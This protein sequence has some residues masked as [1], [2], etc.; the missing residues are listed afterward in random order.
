MAACLDKLSHEQLLAIAAA[1]C[2]A[3][4]GVQKIADAFVR[5]HLGDAAASVML[6]IDLVPHLLAPLGPC[7]GA[8]AAVCKLWAKAWKDT[9]EFR[10]YLTKVAFKFNFPHDVLGAS[11][12]PNTAVPYQHGNH[13]I[14]MAVVS[15]DD[16]RAPFLVVRY[17][18]TVSIVK[19]DMTCDDHFL[20]PSASG[21]I[22]ANHDFIWVVNILEEISFIECRTLGG[23]IVGKWD[24]VDEDSIR[25]I[26]FPVVAPDQLL[27][28]VIFDDGDDTY[29]DKIAALNAMTLELLFTF[30]LHSS[31]APE[32]SDASEP[33]Q[34]V[35]HELVVVGDELFVCDTLNSQLQVFS[36]TG[37]HKRA[38]EGAWQRPKY[39]C[40]EKDRLYLVEEVNTSSNCVYMDCGKRIFVLS[41]KGETLQVLPVAPSPTIAAEIKWYFLIMP[42]CFDGKLLVPMRAVKKNNSNKKSNQIIADSDWSYQ[43]LTL[44]GV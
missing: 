24:V 17:G 12:V 14:S 36:H 2:E 10:R 33:H 13:D 20:V 3:S 38:I 44:I 35:P 40:F 19:Q 18:N 16:T 29:Y 37:E 28:C 9:G 31:E 6:S 41:L 43:M 11:F 34:F 1:G 15:G 27:F 32:A 25:E 8:A 5:L 42:R 7:D 23:I 39:L 21:D 26:A 22:A 30:G 4:G